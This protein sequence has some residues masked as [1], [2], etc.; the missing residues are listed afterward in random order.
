MK[1]SI[2]ENARK[3]RG[4][5]FIDS[6]DKEFKETIK[7]ARKKLETPVAPAMPCKIMMKNCVSGASNKIKSRLACILEGDGSTTLRMGESLQNHH[8]DH[9]AG[10]GDNSLQHYNLV[11]KFI[12]LPQ[13]MKIPA[14]K[15]AV[16]KESENWRN[17]RAWNLTKVRSKKEVIDARTSDAKV[18]FASLMDICHLKNT[19]L[20]AKHQKYKGRGSIH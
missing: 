16:D 18:H 6:E 5:Y 20:E 2:W 15:A 12:P 14:A 7:N 3:L 13:A 19:E 9:I 8:E 17:F 10:K 1:S 11:H 4:I